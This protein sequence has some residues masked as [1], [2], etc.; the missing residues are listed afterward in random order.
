[1]RNWFKKLFRPKTKSVLISKELGT[2][3]AYLTNDGSHYVAFVS[4]PITNLP[5]NEEKNICG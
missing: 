2:T 5:K 4:I 3:R 1:M